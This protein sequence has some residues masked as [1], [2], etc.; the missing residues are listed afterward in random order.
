MRSPYLHSARVQPLNPA[1]LAA[2][3]L[4]LSVGL[5]Y[6]EAFFAPHFHPLPDILL[7]AL[8][9]LGLLLVNRQPGSVQG[10]RAAPLILGTLGAAVGHL[11]VHVLGLTPAVAGSLAGILA[12]LLA[13]PRV[14]HPLDWA[15]AAY[16]G[17][18]A[19]TGS[20]DVLDGSAWILLAGF[21]SGA[22]WCMTAG[23]WAG[24]GGK[25]GFTGLIGN[26][27]ALVVFDFVNG[28]TPPL[29]RFQVT[30]WTVDFLIPTAVM[31]ALTTRLLAARP[32]W[33]PVLA[34]AAPSLLF[35]GTLSLLQVPG[36]GPLSAAWF[37]GS[38]VGMT[39]PNR[40]PSLPWVA[41]AATFY[42]AALLHLQR[43]LIGHGGLLGTTALI[44]VLAALALHQLA[45][46][47]WPSPV[48]H[49]ATR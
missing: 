3:L 32:G 14:G 7:A 48:P 26:S 24:L 8:A 21:L 31:A 1:W 40:L 16:G 29:L 5:F 9:G 17:V 19:G 18:F 6:Q 34:S 44:S 15:A 35:T 36:E 39:A 33:N 20:T 2:G 47:L 41:L 11:A 30:G 28:Y 10:L 38:F 23:V 4:T 42:G 25:M 12:G 45:Q 37:G 43:P 22:V 46:R 49:S 13:H 27:L